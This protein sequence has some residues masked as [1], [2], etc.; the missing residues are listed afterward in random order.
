MMMSDTSIKSRPT[1]GQ[2]KLLVELLSLDWYEPIA[3]KFSV[4]KTYET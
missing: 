1:K 4:I 3:K 2:M